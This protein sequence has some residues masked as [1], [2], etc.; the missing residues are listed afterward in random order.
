VSHQLYHGDNREVLV[1]HATSSVH[2]VVC[3]PPYGLSFMGKEWDKAVPGVEYWDH[4]WDHCLRVLRPGGYLAAFG[5]TRTFHRLACAIEDAGFDIK[6][7]LVWLYGSGFPKSRN[8]RGEHEGQ[9][10]AL[11]PGWEPIILAQKPMD[12]TLERNVRLW[13]TG[14]LQIDACRI[15][16]TDVAYKRNCSGDRGQ[17]QVTGR[18]NLGFMRT[19]GGGQAS[20]KGRW[21]ANVSIDEEA[22]AMLDAQTGN[23]KS[24]KPGTIRKGVNTGTAYGAESRP[25]GT[26]MTGFGD[27]GG[28]SRFYYCSK[29]SRVERDL[30]CEG[31]PEL[32]LNWS[33]GDQ[34]PGSFQSEGTKKAAR[35]NVPTVKPVALMRWL[36]RLVTPRGGTVADPFMGSGSTGM[37]ALLEGLDFIG[38]EQEAGAF[39][40]ASARIAHV[41]RQ[42]R[43]AA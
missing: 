32:P 9:G 35:N 14:A 33:A 42:M 23:L 20:D 11:K 31:L 27:E 18:T 39:E 22:A 30:G 25:P 4:Y 21:P 29:V 37:A 26:P 16:V 41:D 10:T 34:N 13:G 8:L 24:G 3:D 36:C 7:C 5:G 43:G 2:S 28:A 17:N 6:D 1:S 12:G 15:E 19:V 38:I 40:I